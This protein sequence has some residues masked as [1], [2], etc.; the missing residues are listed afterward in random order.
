MASALPAARPGSSRRRVSAT[1]RRPD[2]SSDSTGIVTSPQATA[3]EPSNEELL[4]HLRKF[5]R[6]T[7]VIGAL[8][9][10]TRLHGPGCF[11]L[12]LTFRQASS[13]RPLLNYDDL[14]KDPQIQK[15]NPGDPRIFELLDDGRIIACSCGPAT[16]SHGQVIETSGR[17]RTI[18]MELYTRKGMWAIPKLLWD[19]SH[20]R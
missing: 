8:G 14:A 10:F 12:R 11:A 16:D 1:K 19:H 6:R 20:L 9:S 5:Q 4:A 3:P 13:E 7:G 18:E 2:G 15:M 17:S